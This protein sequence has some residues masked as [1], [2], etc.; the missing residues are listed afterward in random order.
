MSL[1]KQGKKIAILAKLARKT[2]IG[3]DYIPKQKTYSKI[4]S[5]ARGN[6]DTITEELHKEGLIEYHKGKKMH[7][8]KPKIN[9]QNSRTN[10]RRSTKLHNKETTI[11]TRLL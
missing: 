9:T 5:H 2:K 8:T 4:P 10:T 11:K 1:D 7:I 3:M 6:L